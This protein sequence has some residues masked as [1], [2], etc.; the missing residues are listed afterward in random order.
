MIIVNSQFLICLY[1]KKSYIGS[2]KLILAKTHYE[3]RNQKLLKIVEAF[4]P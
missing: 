2:K 1:F 3:T 4:K